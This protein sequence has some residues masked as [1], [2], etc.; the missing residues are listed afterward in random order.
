MNTIGT[1]LGNARRERSVSLEQLESITKIKRNFIE[2]IEKEDWEELPEYPVVLGFVRNIAGSLDVSVESALALLRRDYPPKVLKVT[3]NPDVEKKFSWSPRL[4]FLLGISSFLLILLGYLGFQYMQFKSPP[5]LVINKPKE[6]EVVLSNKV[7]VEGLTETDANI[8]I[9]NQP[10]IVDSDG[11]F[12]G[13][14][15]VSKDTKELIIKAIA[16][17]GKETVVNRKISVE[18][19]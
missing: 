3:P 10:L 8:E 6:G 1:V 11:N 2:A 13:E 18:F 14:I 7:L 17:S 4:T 12:K 16:R 19:D 9:N 5:K 15:E